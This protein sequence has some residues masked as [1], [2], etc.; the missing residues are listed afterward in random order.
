MSGRGYGNSRREIFETHYSVFSI[1]MSG[2]SGLEEGDKILLPPSS[3]DKLSRMEIEYPMLFELTN[4]PLDKRTHCGVLEFTAEEGRCYMPFWMMQNLFLE[5]G[6]LVKVKNVPLKK[7]TYV[8]LKAQSVDFLDISNPKAVLEKVLRKYTCLTTND[9]ICLP[10]LDKNFFMEVTEVKPD[11]AA[12][13]VEADVEVD[14][15]EP[16]GYVA[17]TR[18]GEIAA[19]DHSTGTGGEKSEDGNGNVAA[20]I[21]GR[22]IQRARVDNIDD[23]SKDNA[24]VFEAFK[25]GA[26]RIDGKAKRDTDAAAGG[27]PVIEKVAP[28]AAEESPVSPAVKPSF[29]SKIGDKFSTKKSSASAFG[30]AGYKLK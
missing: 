30:G 25:G 9:M 6:A 11:G 2:R 29:K 24:N 26:H 17:P 14:F 21:L 28:K 4:E 1:A 12:S 7:A 5:E 16:V 18:P 22:A 8:K 23:K 27:T 19:S 15:D 10:Y 3:F 20:N 13:I